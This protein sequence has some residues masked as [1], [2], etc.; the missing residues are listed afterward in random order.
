MMLQTNKKQ[1]LVATTNPAKIKTFKI[2]LDKLGYEALSFA[3]LGIGLEEPAETKTTAEEIAVEK[4]LGYAK[5]YADLPVL[6]RDDTTA[7]I[8]VDEEDDPK[9]HNKEFVARRK[10][11]YS[12]ANGEL[13]FSEIAHKYGGEVPVRF[14]WGYALAWH[15]DGEIKVV[16]ATASNEVEKV[17]L[18]DEISETKF[19]GFCFSSVL[20]V[21]TKNGWKFDSE[22]SEEDSWEAYW[23]CQK[24]AIESLLTQY[25]QSIRTFKDI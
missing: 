17:K 18:V 12:D 4:A 20:K 24:D 9:N 10:G 8:G 25:E 13:V 7:L 6:A 14:D 19:P 22:L 15:Q 5:Q 16:S 11:E 21:K 1:V 2:I 23:N 3:D